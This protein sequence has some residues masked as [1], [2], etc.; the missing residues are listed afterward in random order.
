MRVR[1][2]VEATLMGIIAA[3][4]HPR[5]RR[6]NRL[7]GWM[8][9]GIHSAVLGIP[10]FLALAGVYAVDVGKLEGVFY[11]WYVWYAFPIVTVFIAWLFIRAGAFRSGGPARWG[12][13]STFCTLLMWAIVF[14]CHVCGNDFFGGMGRSGA[15]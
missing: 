15:R 1:M 9:L 11:V 14:S 12:L 7:F 4:E 13:L 5:V 8:G 2:L 10:F 6:F 3:Q